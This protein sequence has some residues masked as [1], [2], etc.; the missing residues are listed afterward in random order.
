MVGLSS[1]PSAELLSNLNTI[2]ILYYLDVNIYKI[3]EQIP[4]V[5]FE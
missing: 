5:H 2:F 1:K 3:W 4:L